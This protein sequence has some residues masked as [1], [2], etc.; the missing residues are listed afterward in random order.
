MPNTCRFSD[1]VRNRCQKQHE[2]FVQARLGGDGTYGDPDRGRAC[3]HAGVWGVA[4][5]I[6]WLTG[7]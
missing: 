6:A 4:Q 1:L 5:A 3:D 7:S 2:D